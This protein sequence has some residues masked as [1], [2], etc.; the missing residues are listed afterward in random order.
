MLLEEIMRLPV[1]WL[2]CVCVCSSMASVDKA[3]HRQHVHFHLWSKFL[4][5]SSV[6]RRWTKVK[7]WKTS[8]NWRS[9]PSHDLEGVQTKWWVTFVL[10]KHNAFTDLGEAQTKKWETFV[11]WRHQP[12]YH[13]GWVWTKGWVPFALCWQ[14]S[15]YLGKWMEE[16]GDDGEVHLDIQKYGRRRW[17]K[18]RSGKG[19]K[20]IQERERER[21]RQRRRS[22]DRRRR[23]IKERKGRRKKS[24]GERKKRVGETGKTGKGTEFSPPL[25][26]SR[27]ERNIQFV[28]VK[29]PLL[30]RWQRW[31]VL[32]KKTEPN[33]MFNIDYMY[34][35]IRKYI[36]NCVSA[37][38]NTNLFLI[39]IWP[40]ESKWVMWE[41]SWVP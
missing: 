25:H 34:G 27:P 31:S 5:K 35:P 17:G 37:W 10:W 4:W 20:E 38:R 22:K 8:V 13:R 9:W 1:Q 41:E 33:G 11:P 12:M 2:M 24:R 23:T 3:H 7:R 36:I 21:G 39:H 19:R 16:V 15:F 29:G 30:L 18:E 32:Q 14:Q 6:S 28:S 26:Q 40:E